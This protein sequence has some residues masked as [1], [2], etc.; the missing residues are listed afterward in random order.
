MTE[1]EIGITVGILIGL[2][3]G[4]IIGMLV[5][6]LCSANKLSEICDDYERKIAD[7]N[8]INERLIEE[9]ESV[10][11]EVNIGLSL[12]TGCDYDYKP[13]FGIILNILNVTTFESVMDGTYRPYNE[14]SDV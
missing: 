2:T 12:T 4:S 5:A 11:H 8:V 6:G 3:L 10:I 7:M 9:R 1:M 13:V 14:D